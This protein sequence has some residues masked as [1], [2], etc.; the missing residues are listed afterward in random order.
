VG[1]VADACEGE[2]HANSLP[3]T[4][5]T[6][7]QYPRGSV[8]SP[9][10]RNGLYHPDTVKGL[11]D[12]L[13]IWIDSDGVDDTACL[14]IREE[15]ITHLG[16]RS[17]VG[18]GHAKLGEITQVPPAR[19]GRYHVFGGHLERYDDG[20]DTTPLDQGVEQGAARYCALSLPNWNVESSCLVP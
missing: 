16:D 15:R 8:Q 11:A 13:A 19:N 5:G 18:H 12:Q 17:L 14:G 20:I 7:Q 9:M 2:C 3:H 4:P 10:R 1:Q 6:D